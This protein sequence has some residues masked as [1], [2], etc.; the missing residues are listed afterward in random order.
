MPAAV[1]RMLTLLCSLVVTLPVG[2]NLGMVHLLWMLVSG[3]LLE[4]RGAVIPALSASGLSERA[5]RRA[6]AALGQGDWTSGALLARWRELVG[7]EGHWQPHTHEGYHP[8]GV[9]V[10]GFWRPQLVDCPTRHYNAEAGK[11]LPAIPLGLIGRTGSVG[12]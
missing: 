11:A 7:A 12:G 10:T 4:A 1:Y 8:V 9:D 3:R 6:W 2:T 5:V